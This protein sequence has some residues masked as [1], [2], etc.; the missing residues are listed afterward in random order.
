MT[1][2]WRRGENPRETSSLYEGK[3]WA[4]LKLDHQ[5]RA[6][7]L[8]TEVEATL[9]S[10]PPLVKEAWIRMQGWYC[11]FEDRPPFVKG[12]HRANDRGED[13]SIPDFHPRQGGPFR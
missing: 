1:L 5:H 8:R 2:G 10:N 6:A 12:D 9:A 4:S 7:T 11:E 13:S 3:V